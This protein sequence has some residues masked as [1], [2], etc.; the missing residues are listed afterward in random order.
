MLPL[1]IAGREAPPVV[2]RPPDGSVEVWRDVS[3]TTGAYAYQAGRQYW[4]DVSNVA[5]FHYSDATGHV[6]AVAHGAIP[7][8]R[9][10]AAYHR[11]VLP[12]LLQAL[13]YEMLHASAVRTARGVVAFCGDSGAGKSTIAVGLSQRGYPL[14]ADDALL[15][16]AG[17]GIRAI[18]LPFEVRL[19]PESA[20]FFHLEGRLDRAGRDRSGVDRDPANLLAVCVLNQVGASGDGAVPRRRRGAAALAA[21]LAHACAFSLADLDRKRRMME[22]YFAVSMRVPV[23]DLGVQPGLERLP[24]LLDAVERRVIHAERDGAE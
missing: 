24:D 22:H 2:P 16:E 17:A 14:W 7:E 19:R 23:F 5:M 12:M 21:L 8:V 20:E 4:V 10:R 18:G 6:T 1:A 11:I 13:G 15:F 9:V 3:G